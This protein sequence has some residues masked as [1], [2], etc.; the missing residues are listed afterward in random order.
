M[1]AIKRIIFFFS[2]LLVIFIIREFIELYFFIREINVYLAYVALVILFAGMFYFLVIPIITILRMPAIYAPVSD[3]SSANEL[4]VK[5]I[6]NFKTNKYLLESRF[7]FAN[8]KN[9][10]QSYE[11]IILVLSAQAAVIRRKYVNQLFYSTSI[12]QNGFLDAILILSASLNL[13]KEIFILYNGRVSNREVWI[14]TKKV[15]YSIVIGGSEGVEYATEEIYSK[16]ATSS[17][18]SIPFLDKLLS[19]VVDG[20]INAAL[21]TRVSLITE[22]YCK[23]IY[24]NNDKDLY[25]SAKSVI[26]TTKDITFQ[27][28]KTINETLIKMVK[29][30]SG[31]LFMRG[32]NPVAFVLGK[33]YES[34]KENSPLKK[35]KNLFENSVTFIKGLFNQ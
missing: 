24:L 22:N 2:A 20:F 23:T 12:S 7:D 1:K 33:S 31:D 4:L 10:M 3:Q 13:I 27:M 26:S 14:I 8:I 30:K 18:K 6:A 11:R 9:D 34:L 35:G 16:M 5:R 21:L 29:N 15:Y 25:P 17:L 32:M 19:S 28:I